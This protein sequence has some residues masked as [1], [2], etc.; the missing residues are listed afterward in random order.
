M[1]LRGRVD[2][3]H[4]QI[5]EFLRERGC[6]LQSLA[7]IG[8]GCP[9]LLVG[10]RQQN[11]LMEVKNGLLRP[12][13]RVLTDEEAWWHGWWRGQVAVVESEEDVVRV[14]EL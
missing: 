13:R 4:Q 7:N 8:K 6:T 1:R 3:N 2:D 9:D 10:F 14:L 5:V 12:S 11:I